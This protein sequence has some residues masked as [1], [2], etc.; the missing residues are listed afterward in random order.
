MFKL[1]LKLIQLLREIQQL[2]RK[3]NQKILRWK[4]KRTNI[5]CY[6]RVIVTDPT[7][8]PTIRNQKENMKTASIEVHLLVRYKITQNA[9]FKI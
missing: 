2:L 7:P 8:T 6:R 3:R 4:E 1:V 9:Q 5:K